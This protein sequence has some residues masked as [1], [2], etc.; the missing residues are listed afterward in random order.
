MQCLRLR[1]PGSPIRDSLTVTGGANHE[2]MQRNNSR[3]IL[4][5]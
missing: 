2:P 1:H 5:P 3:I 4:N